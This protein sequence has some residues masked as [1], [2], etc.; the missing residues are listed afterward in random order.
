MRGLGSQ[1]G[2]RKRLKIWA[3]SASLFEYM[4][5]IERQKG[6]I[7]SQRSERLAIPTVEPMLDVAGNVM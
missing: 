2:G 7:S 6:S 3:S 1:P 4:G 5:V